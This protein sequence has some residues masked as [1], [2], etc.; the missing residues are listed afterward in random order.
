MSDPNTAP[1]GGSN[2]ESW[3]Q[4]GYGGGQYTGQYPGQYRDGS[5]GQTPPPGYYQGQYQGQY[6][7]QY[8]GQ[9][10]AYGTYGYGPGGWNAPQ[11]THGMTTFA[12]VTGIVAATISVVPFFGFVAFLLGPLAMVLGIVGIAKRLNRRGF[13]VTALVTG[14]FALLVSILYAVLFT[15][16]MT[17]MDRSET[18]EFVASSTG[19]YQISLTTTEATASVTSNQRGTFS[20]SHDASVI[21]GGVIAT[22]V[23]DNS[24][25]VS[26]E[27]FD[28]E[29][30][31]V[32]E[33][34]DEGIG[35]QA[36]CMIGASWLE[37]T[38]DYSVS[39]ELNAM[40]GH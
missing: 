34:E 32:I 37:N 39:D 35:A 27:V 3:N 20:E 26:C 9:Y 16:L 17:F 1:G 8:P 22:N 2:H 24:G 19:E 28:S 36:Q 12:M 15:T 18:Y 21:F 40:A 5:T 25:K 33:D 7:G 38:E 13:S 11:R 14:A 6:A 31:L 29:G 4:Q 23:G 10:P 30:Y